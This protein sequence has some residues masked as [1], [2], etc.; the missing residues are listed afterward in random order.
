MNSLYLAMIILGLSAQDVTKKAYNQ[1]N[2]AVYLFTALTALAA[3]IFFMAT[4]DSLQWTV[5]LLPYSAAF[6][7]AYGLTTVCCVTAF[8]CGSLSLSALIISYSLML[9]T[10]YG[11]IFLHE[12]VGVGLIPGIVLLI[13]SL[14]LIHKRGENVPISPKWIINVSL[15]FVGNGF[16]SITQKVQQNAFEGAFKN[17]F[18]ILAL[19]FVAVAFIV[20]AFRS[21]R[22]QI[23]SSFQNGWWLCLICG[24]MNGMVNL[25]VM[26]LSGRMPVS[27]M[28]PVISAGG[29]VVTSLISICFYR[30]KM[31]KQQLAG[32]VLGVATV[33]LLNL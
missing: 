30:E 23:K 13:L 21:E 11:L 4:A 6:A 17:E 10:I 5:R 14:M 15:A 9:P 24:A 32:L 2:S 19:A 7:V 8:S 33:I 28:F 22:C 18:M 25:F 31:S 12:P 16:C 29:I 20:L 3:M 27:I 1:K 26:I